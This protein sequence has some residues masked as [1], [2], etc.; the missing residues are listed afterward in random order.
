MKKISGKDLLRI[1]FEENIILGTV[2]QFCENYQGNLN[3]GE[4]LSQLKKM[5]ETPEF[6]PKESEF[7]DLAQQIIQLQ[8][9]LETDVIPLNESPT[10]F[11]IFGGEHIEEGALKQMQTAI[12]L[13]VSVAGALM[14]DAHQ[15]YGL[16]IGG[17]LA[18]KNAIIPYGVGVDIGCRMALSVYNIDELF[19]LENQAKFKRE[20]IAQSNFGAGNGFRGQYKSDHEVLENKLF[21]EN[22]LLRN[23]KDKAWAQLG[24]SGGGNHFVEFGIIE[25]AE[26]DEVLNIDKGTYVALLTHSGSRGFGATIA[27]HYT[28]LAKKICKLP[29]EAKNLAYFD[30]NSTEGQEYWL[31]MNLAGDY[32]SACHQIIHQK[33]AK[34]L[35]AEVLATV[36]NH[37]NFAWKE[38]WNGEEVIVHRKGA[39]PASKDVMGIIPGSMT[40]PGFLVRGKGNTEAIQSAS[41]G[42]GRQMSRTQAKKE[43]STSD[44][45]SIL[46]DH[47]VTLIGA[48]LDEAPMAYKDIHQVMEAQK[49]LVDVVAKFTPKMV[50]MADDGSRED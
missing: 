28:Q 26:R 32:A 11:Q 20:L 16:P 21:Q 49:D 25:F 24:S 36:E 46:K 33:M 3:K 38:T 6:T 27:G 9:S 40:A 41:H 48:G 8:K 37:H 31:A 7:Y 1:G 34:A 39:T 45:K 50:R 42:A 18:T 44:F 22:D 5:V 15:G 29:Q 23:L 43:I 17:V 13:P 4:V 47:N 19:F 14:P 2:L 35:G 30:L 12:K 10:E